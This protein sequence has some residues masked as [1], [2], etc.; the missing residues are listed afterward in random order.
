MDPEDAH[1]V[2]HE[3]I[4]VLAQTL[5]A[6]VVDVGGEIITDVTSSAGHEYH[7][8]VK[9]KA[10]APGKVMITGQLSLIGHPN[11]PVLQDRVEYSIINAEGAGP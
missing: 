7:V 5:T 9:S 6:G 10:G 1:G 3:W 4:G 8:V 11:A 2:L